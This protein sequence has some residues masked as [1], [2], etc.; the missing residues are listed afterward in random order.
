[1]E[2][3]T[4]ELKTVNFKYR[5]KEGENPPILVCDSI[6]GS[7]KTQA[8]IE[9]INNSPPW[10]KF[11]YVTPY[12]TEI[13]RIKK[14]CPRANFVS[15]DFK[16]GKGSKMTDFQRLFDEGRNIA[17][18]HVLFQMFTPENF[19]I[20][21]AYGYIL[22]MDE[23]ADVVDKYKCN[24]N[25]LYNLLNPIFKYV[26]IDENNQIVANK[27]SPLFRNGVT[28]EAANKYK[29]QP[30]KPSKEIS[31]ENDRENQWL[32]ML[33]RTYCGCLYLT[34]TSKE[35]LKEFYDNGGRPDEI[36][37]N[38]IMW[39][40]PVSIFKAFEKVFIL[41]YMFDGQYQAN[42]Y[43]Y[44]NVKYYFLRTEK[45]SERDLETG[46]PRY[47]FKDEIFNTPDLNFPANLKDLIQIEQDEKLNQIGDFYKKPA[48]KNYLE[49]ALCSTWYDTYV[50]NSDSD[51]AKKLSNNTYNF[52]HNKCKC[53][54]STDIIWTTFKT[55][56]SM[57]KQKP[58]SKD[59]CFVSCTARA[60]NE[61]RNRH[62]CAYLINVY[63]D[64]F[65]RNFFTN[66]GINPNQDLYALSELIQWLFRSAIRQG[67]PIKLYIPSQ[68][69][70]ELLE[71]WLDGNYKY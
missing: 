44:F 45:L 21:E 70:R 18:T 60:T 19:K 69:M 62:K 28:T 25:D 5:K 30:K 68:R 42:Y 31:K 27:E 1:M 37:V 56:Q 39:T 13:E 53:S 6:C 22:I 4:K 33:Y 66:R 40:F 57:I 61:Y 65:I 23:V 41:T 17:C 15:P 54:S 58:F 67:E 7:G 63:M 52:F 48:S 12:L 24:K 3:R 59:S 38:V 36:S 46:A 50:L 26:S 34:G 20:A 35:K 2:Y 47:Q 10:N 9:Y 32:D 8:A 71:D 43:K 14:S 64:P 51:A 55:Y 49:S 29:L 11:L 16:L